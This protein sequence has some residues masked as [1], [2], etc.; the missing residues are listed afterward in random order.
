MSIHFNR[1]S[2][3]HAQCTASQTVGPTDGETDDVIM[4]IADH[5]ACNTIGKKRLCEKVIGTEALERF[6]RWGAKMGKK[7]IR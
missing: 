7:I 3:S 5:I 1:V 6:F 2:F 4:P